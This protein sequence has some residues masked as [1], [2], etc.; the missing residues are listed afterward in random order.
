[1]ATRAITPEEVAHV[2]ELVARGRAALR[3]FD[4]ASQDQVDRLCQAMAW[5]VAN[6]TTFTRLAHMGVDESG[7]GD[8]E[9]G[10]EAL[11]GHRNPA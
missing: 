3:E 1:M 11:Q 4:G 8:R 7:I 9:P 5:S 2:D 10:L 6:E